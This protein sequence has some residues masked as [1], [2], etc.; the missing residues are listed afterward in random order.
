VPADPRW[1]EWYE[2]YGRAVY[3]FIRF[4]VTSPDEA[5]DLAAETF[6]RAFRGA[7]R[8][9]PARASVKTWILSIAR[10]AVRDH[11]RRARVRRHLPLAGLRDLAS[12]HPSPEERLL[13]QE[14]VGRLLAAMQR[15]PERDR[16]IL[17]LRYGSEL[18][19]AGIAATLG[20]RDAAARTRL[21]R[22]L[23]RLRAELDP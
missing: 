4:H 9:D 8:F 10:N 7:A 15:L 6:L 22:A 13:W 11:R 12:D 16:E 19:P 1:Q 23:Q 20:I 5:E 21:W 18:E 17:G 3:G 2:A 14:Q